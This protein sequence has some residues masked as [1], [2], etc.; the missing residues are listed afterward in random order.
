MDPLSKTKQRC[1]QCVFYLIID[2]AYGYC[3]RF[4]PT[5]KEKLKAGWKTYSEDRY[6]IVTFDSSICG[7]F[8]EKLEIKC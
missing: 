7:E 5:I 3:R 2:S 4:P 6:P 1:E 8:K